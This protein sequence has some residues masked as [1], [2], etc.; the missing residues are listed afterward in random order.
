MFTPGIAIFYL[1]TILRFE[2]GNVIPEAVRQK[3]FHMIRPGY[4]TWLIRQPF[5]E[6]PPQNINGSSP[7]LVIFPR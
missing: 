2:A 6:A 4:A 1:A 3:L 5:R 7:A